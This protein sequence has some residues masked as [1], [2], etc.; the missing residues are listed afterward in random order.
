[1]PEA[2]IVDAVRTPIGRAFKGS[3]A[4]LRPDEMGAFVVD[5]APRAQPGRGPGAD[6]GP[7]L[8]LR[9]AAGPP[10]LQHRPDHLAALRAASGR[11]HRRHDLAL[12][13]LEPRVDPGGRQRGH[14]RAG[15]RLHR[16]R[17]GVGLALQRAHR[18]GRRG[19]PERASPGQERRPGRLHLDGADGRERGRQVR[20]QPLR[21]GQVR[22]AL[23]GAGRQVTGGRLLRPRD[24]AGHAPRRHRGREGRRP[25]RQ[26]DAREA[27]AARARLPPRRQGHRRQLVSAQRRRGR[28]CS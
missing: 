18:G 11:R 9:H 5:A 1:M 20:G 24:R 15:R 28:R 25:A 3:L 12:L 19:G 16:G 17:R 6:R 2:V 22:P 10:G 27:R 14:G 26:L 23:A 8:R 7:L 13:R 4:Q 21:H